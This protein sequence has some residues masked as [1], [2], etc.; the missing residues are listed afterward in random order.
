MKSGNAG[1]GEPRKDRINHR[2]VIVTWYT[3]AE[4]LP[5]DGMSVPATVSG[6]SGNV[7][8]HRA[9]VTVEYWN[10]EGWVVESKEF[11]SARKGS[12]LTVHAWADLEP[13]GGDA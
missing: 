12:W 4:K 2:Q 3:P 7:R 5:P 1:T 8:F 13:Y 10:G 9:L 6:E 11:D